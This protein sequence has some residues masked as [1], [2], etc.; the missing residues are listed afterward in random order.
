MTDAR[1]KEEQVK[2]QG[3]TLG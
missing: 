3:K 1:H 2:L